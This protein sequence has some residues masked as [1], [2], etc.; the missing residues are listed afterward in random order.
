M[1]SS[2]VPSLGSFTI[3]PNFIFF[4]D[5]IIRHKAVFNHPFNHSSNIFLPIHLSIWK[6]SPCHEGSF[7]V[8]WTPNRLEIDLDATKQLYWRC[9][10][11]LFYIRNIW[12][13]FLFV[14]LD[15]CIYKIPS[16]FVTLESIHMSL[17]CIGIKS[18]LSR[19]L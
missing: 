5:S 16:G 3:V 11:L 19:K 7:Y 2:Q 18:L 1:K 10:H 8:I 13:I 6:N 14:D 12:N 9:Q 17:I 15:G 4:R